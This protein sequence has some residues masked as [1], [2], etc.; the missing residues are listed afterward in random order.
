MEGRRFGET[1][2]VAS[3][4]ETAVEGGSD[5]HRAQPE[6]PDQ[7]RGQAFA[8]VEAAYLGDEGAGAELIAPLRQLGPEMDTFATIPAPALGQLHMDPTEPVPALGDGIL[9]TDFPAAAADTLVAVVGPDA[10]TPLTSV[11]IRQLGGALGRPASGAGAQPSIEASYLLF[12]TGIAP[13]SEAATTVREHA[14]TVRDA[15][16]PGTPAT[17]TTTSETFR[18]QLTRCYRPTPTGASSRS[19]PATTRTA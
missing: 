11:E 9:L 8:L 10:D 4:T 14:Q 19:K 5:E 7:V 13:T 3:L 6:L 17:T 2:E 12:C 18:S 1:A 16:A 15:A